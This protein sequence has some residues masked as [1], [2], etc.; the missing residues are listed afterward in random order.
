M[1]VAVALRKI[2]SVQR[3]SGDRWQAARRGGVVTLRIDRLAPD[4]RFTLPVGWR[5]VVKSEFVAMAGPA[6]AG[7]WPPTLNVDTD[8]S[9]WLMRAEYAAYA[10][11]TFTVA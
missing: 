11:A 3:I 1:V 8:G 5:P 2:G 10:T 4:A 9:V 7:K 6:E